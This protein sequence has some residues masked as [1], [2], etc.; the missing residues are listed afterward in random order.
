MTMAKKIEYEHI[1]LCEHCIEAIR[2]RGEKVWVG[3]II[4]REEDLDNEENWVPC[5]GLI[6]EW[7]EHDYSTYDDLYDCHF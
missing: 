7:C 2:S 5:D 6:C 3:E 4:E 1:R